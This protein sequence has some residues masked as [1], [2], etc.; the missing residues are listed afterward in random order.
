M[1]LPGTMEKLPEKHKV[2]EWKTRRVRKQPQ[3]F[4]LCLPGAL[5]VTIMDTFR[6]LTT[7]MLFC[8]QS[9]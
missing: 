6:I 8:L 3:S 5:F 4:L 9:R 7:N 1:G 2:A